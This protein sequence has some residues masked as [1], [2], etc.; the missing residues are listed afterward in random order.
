M[1][2]SKFNYRKNLKALFYAQLGR[3]LIHL[4]PLKRLQFL[5]GGGTRLLGCQTWTMIE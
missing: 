1:V 2:E 4:H 3:R 5:A